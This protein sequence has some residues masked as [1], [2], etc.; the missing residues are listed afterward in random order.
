M[1]IKQFNAIALLL[2]CLSLSACSTAT[3][4]ATP[5]DS[6]PSPAPAVTAANSASQQAAP[7]PSTPPANEAPA[8]KPQARV[9]DPE[10]LLSPNPAANKT[11][12]VFG[13][14][15]TPLPPDRYFEANG[16]ISWYG[17]ALQGRRTSSGEAFDMD[18]FTAAHPVLPIPSY[19]R[20]TN[21]ENGIQA[22][23]RIND[24]GPFKEKRMMD[25]SR[26]AAVHLGFASKGL[27]QAKVELMTTQEALAWLRAGAIQPS[28]TTRSAN[29]ATSAGQ[30]SATNKTSTNQTLVSSDVPRG[31][32]AQLGA[33]KDNASALVLAQKADQTARDLKLSSPLSPQEPLVQLV[34]ADTTVG[35]LARVIAGP[36]A[37]RADAEQ[38][39]K[40]LGE[41]LNIKPFITQQ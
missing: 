37:S 20:I 9:V 40:L 21:N 10:A 22:I 23:V 41:A 2:L 8:S 18:A 17:A 32:Y 30:P 16:L 13:T 36:Y 31:F 11:F 35:R 15:Y 26:A 1:H 25:V 34:S 3:K 7:Q 19:A 12:T 33:Y 29:A 14:T 28:T 27:V 6:T 39:A 24:R 5:P 38:A 4:Q